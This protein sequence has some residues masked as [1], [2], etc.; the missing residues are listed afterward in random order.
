L[1]EA[2]WL[3]AL[4][5]VAIFMNPFSTRVFEPDKILLFR[6]LVLIGVAAWVVRTS[7]VAFSARRDTSP[8]SHL[9]RWVRQPI[10]AVALL[11]AIVHLSAALFSIAPRVS[12]G[13]SYQR[14]QG[15]YTVLSYV[16]LFF[17]VLATLR[18]WDQLERLV[19]VLIVTTLPVALYG[20]LQHYGVTLLEFGGRGAEQIPKRVVSTLGNPIFVAAYLALVI[21]LTLWRL[22]EAV[23]DREAMFP[24]LRLA[25]VSVYGA[26]LALQV[27][28]VLFTR[29]RGPLLGLLIELFVFVLVVALIQQRRWVAR[30][31]VGAAALIG[32][33]FTV[34]LLMPES[35]SGV[36]RQFSAPM[37]LNRLSDDSTILGRM[38]AWQGTLDAMRAQPQRLV[39][40]YG[41]D[42]MIRVFNRYM[43]PQ[44]TTL[45][46]GATFDRA[47][48]EVLDTLFTT[49]LLGLASY[50]LLYGLILHLGLR[51]LGLISGRWQRWT[52]AGLMAGGGLAGVLVAWLLRGDLVLAGVGL[53]MGMVAGLVL[54]LI[55]LA[56]GGKGA[57]RRLLEAREG[58]LLAALLAAVI[59]HF[60]EAQFGIG[61]ASTQAYFWLYVAL[62]ILLGTKQ[63]VSSAAV[64]PV[65]RPVHRVPSRRPGRR[66][67][68]G[69]EPRRV[70]TEVPTE[71]MG[72]LI[73][74][75]LVVAFLLGSLSY[76]FLHGFNVPGA[77]APALLLI[78]TTWVVSGLVVLIERARRSGLASA[79]LVDGPIYAVASLGGALPFMLYHRINAQ[80][81][82]R[83]EASFV[84]FFV[85]VLL[86]LIAIGMGLGMDEPPPHRVRSRGRAAP[87][88]ALAILVAVLVLAALWVTNLRL[89]RADIHHKV[90]VT[91]MNAGLWGQAI[92]RFERARELAPHED[93]YYIYL[94]GAYVEQARAAPDPQTRE[95]WMRQAQQAFERGWA[96]S[97]TNS[98]HPRHMGQMYQVWARM[99]SD[100][101]R[102]EMWLRRSLEAYAAAVELNPQSAGLRID[103]GRAYFVLN[104]YDEAAEQFRR[105][106]ELNDREHLAFA[107]A[108]LGDVF[109]VRGDLQQA[110]EAYRQA[111]R[112][113]QQ[114]VLRAKLHAVSEET[115]DVHLQTSLALVYA[116]LGRTED[117]LKEL[118]AAMD[119][120]DGDERER[121][122]ALAE[123]LRR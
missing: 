39:L 68:R 31:V 93:Q 122:E 61:T 25:R 23:R 45:E 95:T 44:L 107:Y 50:L 66:S 29:S 88:L 113:N 55:V 14:L 120:A 21:P 73:A 34:V 75:A 13:G 90:G 33:L 71:T 35:S 72:S 40:G 60:V 30:G 112:Y 86:L 38:L 20:I 59:G 83:L 18:R 57:G 96:L 91:V 27:V 103:L 8:I 67:R 109:T 58:I 76:A 26:A 94:G 22:L 56:V 24:A 51:W 4:P 15:T 46:R 16:A 42:T 114:A 104:R 85:W 92:S 1:I 19:T 37:R 108:G 80:V 53:P 106:V 62:M 52:V 2:G 65:P 70:S 54:Y 81:L 12:L 79:F 5:L 97:P 102:R 121:L 11:F 43:P 115:G 49:G 117:A 119:M 123:R 3:L 100:P 99:T 116:A 101:Q 89:V 87:H 110:L 17:L 10:V 6:S 77:R 84:A 74:V 41:P 9:A 64:P 63:L 7:V 28:C 111:V 78:V 105:V 36:L 69:R 118:R 47:H 32:L 48:N 98:D 82:E